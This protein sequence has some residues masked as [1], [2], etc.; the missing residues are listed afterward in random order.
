MGDA[1]DDAGAVD[2]AW[3]ARRDP[4]SKQLYYHNVVTGETTWVCPRGVTARLVADAPSNGD[5]ESED[6]EEEEE[7]EQQQ[8]QR[9]EDGSKAASAS[10]GAPPAPGSEEYA[11]WW[12][13]YASHY[14]AAMM[15]AN[16][17]ETDAGASSSSA[18]ALSGVLDRIDASRESEHTQSRASA[19]HSED[20]KAKGKEGILTAERDDASVRAPLCPYFE[21]LP[22]MIALYGLYGAGDV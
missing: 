19:S 11:Q 4:S 15:A 10:Y 12:A 7:D 14:Y 1:A 2:A 16:A 17:A 3:F 5:N 20:G 6:D 9:E 22:W 21:R 18:A 8:E 13:A